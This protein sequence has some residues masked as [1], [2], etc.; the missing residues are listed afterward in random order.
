MGNININL[1]KYR[2]KQ[3]VTPPHKLADEAQR[4]CDKIGVPFSTVTLRLL[5][6]ATVPNCTFMQF[7]SRREDNLS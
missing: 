5:S 2:Q 7:S 1:N 6:L 4:L 3:E